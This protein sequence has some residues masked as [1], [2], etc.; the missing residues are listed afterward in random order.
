MKSVQ[1]TYPVHDLIAERWS[2]RAFAEQSVT[3]HEIGSL[4]EAARWAPSC[5]NEQPW[6]FLVAKASD[7]DLFERF[8]DCL[9]DGN[10]WAKRAP[11]LMIAVART[12]FEQS[13]KENRHA[14]HDV[15]LAVENLVLQAE[16]LGL[17][18]H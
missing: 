12:T 9:L 13:E 6:R 8:A 18:T 3:D 1:A 10:S 16:A 7:P 15:G 11:V 2:P 4:L 5:Y 14:W 17:A